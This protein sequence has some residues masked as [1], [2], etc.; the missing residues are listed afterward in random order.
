M[1]ENKVFGNLEETLSCDSLIKTSTKSMLMTFLFTK[2]KA[3]IRFAIR[4]EQFDNYLQK[5]ST[6]WQ[7]CLKTT[8]V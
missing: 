4:F 5:N 2:S 3:Y 1:F 6:I 7:Q 8:V